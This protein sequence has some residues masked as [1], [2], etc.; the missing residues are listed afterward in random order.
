MFHDREFGANEHNIHLATPGECLLM[1]QLGS[2]KRAVK[3]FK[4]FVM[5]TFSDLD[6]R[7][8]HRTETFISFGK[9]AQGYGAA[10]IQNSDQ[11]FPRTQYTTPIL[12][13]NKKEGNDYTGILLCLI[14]VCMVSNRG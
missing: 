2:A 8:G 1:H 11:E 4:C 5:G 6:G 13:P 3:W 9:I 14:L 7:R 12:S 10:L